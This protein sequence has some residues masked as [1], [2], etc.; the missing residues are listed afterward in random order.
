MNFCLLLYYAVWSVSLYS[1]IIWTMGVVVQYHT[2]R[3]VKGSLFPFSCIW[4]NISS[5]A[6]SCVCTLLSQR[7]ENIFWTEMPWPKGCLSV[8]LFN[9]FL[10]QDARQGCKEL[11]RNQ[12]R[13]K[14]K[15]ARGT[16]RVPNASLTQRRCSYLMLIIKAGF[17]HGRC[18]CYFPTPLEPSPCDSPLL[19]PCK[20][21]AWA[22]ANKNSPV[23]GK[24]G[25]AWAPLLW[26]GDTSL[27]ISSNPPNHIICKWGDR[28]HSVGKGQLKRREEKRRQ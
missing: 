1:G 27:C 20:L 3:N 5:V 21:S 13:G 6:H 24:R 11:G 4:R 26:W 12:K 18:F 23:R 28:D 15:A 10:K 19:H 25:P 22:T 16:R 8:G 17:E 9:W 2:I 14:A 7:V